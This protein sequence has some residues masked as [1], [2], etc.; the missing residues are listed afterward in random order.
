MY[1]EEE[2]NRPDFMKR[3]NDSPFRT[4]DHY[5]DSLEDRVMAGIRHKENTRTKT[6][7]VISFLKP[8][9][10]LVASFALVFLLVS[11][12]IKHFLPKSMVEAKNTDTLNTDLLEVYSLSFSLIDENTIINTIISDESTTT[13]D[14]NPDEMLAYLS[15][16]CN[17]LD[18]Y[19][20]IQN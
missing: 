12:P 5:F 10:G 15:S 14:I 11:Y 9:L 4:P 13:P 19:A 7:K 17:D 8:A 20:E 6:A 16:D 2:N 1:E 3:K 18:I